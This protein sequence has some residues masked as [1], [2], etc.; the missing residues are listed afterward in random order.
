[1]AP[2]PQTG[3]WCQQAVKDGSSG[4]SNTKGGSSSGS[5]SSAG[6]ALSDFQ[7]FSQVF[8]NTEIQRFLAQPDARYGLGNLLGCQLPP[9]T[10][11]ESTN[12][13]ASCV[14]MRSRSSSISRKGNMPAGP[15][16][17]QIGPP[18]SRSVDGPPRSTLGSASSNKTLTTSFLFALAGIFGLDI[19]AISFLDPTLTEEDLLALFN[20]LPFRCVVLLEDI[21]DPRTRA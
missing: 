20:S 10:E 7:I 15:R 11:T 12:T 17:L 18:C 9:D 5:S 16:V 21:A 19:Y 3:S 13:S 8:D 2:T 1:M 4:R 6:T 14:S